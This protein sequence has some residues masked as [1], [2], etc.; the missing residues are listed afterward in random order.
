MDGYKDLKIEDAYRD[1][2]FT[3]KIIE[4]FSPDEV[5]KILAEGDDALCDLLEKHGYKESASA[6]HNGYGIYGIRHCGGHLLV[7]IGNSCD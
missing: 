7:Q 1:R 2:T 3:T 6:W 5:S 4:G